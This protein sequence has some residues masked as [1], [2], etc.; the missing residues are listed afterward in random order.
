MRLRKL[1]AVEPVIE[2]GAGDAAIRT[3]PRALPND[4]IADSSRS[5]SPDKCLKRASSRQT[6]RGCCSSSSRDRGSNPSFRATEKRK[7]IRADTEVSASSL[8]HR[9]HAAL[10][11][12]SL[13]PSLFRRDLSWLAF[14]LV[15]N[16][17][18][19]RF[20]AAGLRFSKASIILATAA[21]C[22]SVRS[23]MR[24][25]AVTTRCTPFFG[26][27]AAPWL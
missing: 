12:R 11:A 27:M 18:H 3:E 26:G 5:P 15:V 14:S 22:S 7:S 13:R 23:Q 8:H 1:W 6:K 24:S 2:I 9:G 21:A 16:A 20:V 4:V 19:L 10:I 25:K 17:A